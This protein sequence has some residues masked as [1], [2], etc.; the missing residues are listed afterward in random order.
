[1]GRFDDADLDVDAVRFTA[2]EEGEVGL[3]K[4]RIKVSKT[5]PD[6]FSNATF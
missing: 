6:N 1:M 3:V 5:W 4:G 2:H